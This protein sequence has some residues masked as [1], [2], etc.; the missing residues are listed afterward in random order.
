MERIVNERAGTNFPASYEESLGVDLTDQG[1]QMNERPQEGDEAGQSNRVYTTTDPCGISSS[2]LSLSP[3][4]TLKITVG[5]IRNPNNG[6]WFYTCKAGEPSFG[7]ETYE[8]QRQ[9]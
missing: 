8:R 9:Q 3:E 7:V 4:S 2:S 1:C 5:T 6:G